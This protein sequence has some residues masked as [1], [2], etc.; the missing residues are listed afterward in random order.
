LP[1]TYQFNES[2]GIDIFE[3]KDTSN[4]RFSILSFIC[5]G[6]TF[7]QAAVIQ[8]STTG[9]PSSRKCLEVFLD[10]WIQLF[11]TPTEVVSDRGLQNRGSFAQGLSARGVILRNVGV[12]SPEQL[13]RVER[14]GG[15]LKGMIQRMTHELGL[16]GELQMRGGLAEALSTK[17]SQSRIKG[18]TPCQWVFGKLPREPG[19]AS[20][21]K[22]DMGVIEAMADERDEFA[23]VNEIREE[24]RK[25]FIKE[26]LS[27]RVAKALLRKAAPINKEYGVGMCR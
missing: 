27:R 7:H 22:M 10:K 23:K 9:Q 18:F 19:M 20:D 11:G 14:H 8:S 4:T 5:L 6:T 24:A 2:V 17:N 1:R 25:A 21:E 12:E 26:D 16:S 13:G 15:I 3:V